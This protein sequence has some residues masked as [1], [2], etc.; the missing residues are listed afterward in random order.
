MLAD[1]DSE[2]GGL[3]EGLLR[4]SCDKRL[5]TLGDALRTPVEP[6]RGSVAVVGLQV[7]GRIIEQ[8][9]GKLEAAQLPVLEIGEL[10]LLAA[11]NE[12]VFYIGLQERRAGRESKLRSLWNETMFDEALPELVTRV[13][14]VAATALRKMPEYR[15]D[16]AVPQPCR[17]VQTPLHLPNAPVLRLRPGC[18]RA[19][20]PSAA[21]H[22]R[23]PRMVQLGFTHRITLASSAGKELLELYVGP[24]GQAQMPWYL[25]EPF[26]L[27]AVEPLWHLQPATEL[28]VILLRPPSDLTPSQLPLLWAAAKVITNE[29]KKEGREARKKERKEER[30]LMG[31]N[32]IKLSCVSCSS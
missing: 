8:L 14:V 30:G 28:H 31:S 22:A 1:L 26:V 15:V 17:Q 25:P 5:A 12:S 7:L 11:P 3:Y 32:R 2:L 23:V 13:E 10:V 16:G 19:A 18:G 20:A 9:Q 21:A 24:A 27:V 4:F 6:S 29:G